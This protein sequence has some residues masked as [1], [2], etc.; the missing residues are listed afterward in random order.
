MST[1]K[2]GTVNKAASTLAKA[3][4]AKTSKKERTKAAKHASE[5]RMIKIT[6]ER[7]SEIAKIA[8]DSIS[9]ETRKNSAKKAWETRRKKKAG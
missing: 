4:W 7:R 3:R 6:P 9:T 8:S 5:G 1:R 2:A